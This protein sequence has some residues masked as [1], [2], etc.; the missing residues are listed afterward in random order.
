MKK[1]VRLWQSFT[2]AVEEWVLSGKLRKIMRSSKLNNT[3]S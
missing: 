2:L 3:I 1:I